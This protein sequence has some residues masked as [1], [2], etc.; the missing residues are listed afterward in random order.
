VNQDTGGTWGL[1]LLALA[2]A[3]A[4]WLAISV[5]EREARGQRAVTASVTYNSPEELVLLD[6]IQQL[7][8][9]LSGP[10]SQI[11]TLDPR[12]VSVRV[13]LSEVD[14][15]THTLSLGPG[16][17]SLP[18]NLR[19]ESITPNQVRVE[20]DRRESKQLRVEPIFTGEP[21]AGATLGQVTV[22]PAEVVV[23]GPASRLAGIDSVETVPISLDGHALSF[24]ETAAVSSPDPLVQV[25]QPTRVRV[26]IPLRL[27]QPDSQTDGAN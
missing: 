17:V 15:G 26:R 1:R 21:A 12:Q 24:E 23:E 11:S 7:Q 22:I 9:L 18:P 19:V 14:P 20:I 3:V 27:S 2:I 8:V 25:Q 6:P 4:L 5:D 13:D 10:D 16:D